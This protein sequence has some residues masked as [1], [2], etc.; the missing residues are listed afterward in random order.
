[1][2]SNRDKLSK[3]REEGETNILRRTNDLRKELQS[4]FDLQVRLLREK[5]EVE[6]SSG[7]VLYQRRLDEVANRW[8]DFVSTTRK[9][10]EMKFCWS[11][12]A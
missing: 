12:L 8:G 11:S 2:K 9:C 3:Q 10:V 5:S 4:Q 1:M 7:A 6:D